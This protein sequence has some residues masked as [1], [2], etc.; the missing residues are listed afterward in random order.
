[1]F[2]SKLKYLYGITG[3]FLFLFFILSCTSSQKAES[4]S[5]NNDRG[6]N[7][8]NSVAVKPLLKIIDRH[9]TSDTHY[10]GARCPF[11]PTCS[12]WGEHAIREHGITGFLLLLD[13]MIYRET[14]SRKHYFPVS[15]N[16]SHIQRLFDPPEDSMP[17]FSQRR[18]SLLTED[19]DRP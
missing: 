13:R 5:K 8:E 9:K 16:K 3:C 12:H 2:H 11:Y 17:V 19:F 7:A 15:T 6:I 18:P 4:N 1:M 10:D 14:G